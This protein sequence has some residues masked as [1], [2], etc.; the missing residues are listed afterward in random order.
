MT[1]NERGENLKE[2]M[3]HPFFRRAHPREDHFVP[4]YIAAGAGSDADDGAQVLAD[5]H[6][7]ISVAFGV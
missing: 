3:N 7:A 6:S 1:A 5:I 4:I 2:L